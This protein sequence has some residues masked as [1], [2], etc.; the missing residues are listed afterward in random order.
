MKRLRTVNDLLLIGKR[1]K[2]VLSWHGGE[3][4]SDI[5]I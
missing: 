1:Q 3:E 5:F 4:Y 2:Q